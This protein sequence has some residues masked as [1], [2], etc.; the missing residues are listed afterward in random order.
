V[1]VAVVAVRMVQ[2][3]VH[4]VVRVIAMRHGFMPAVG[5]MLV[6]GFVSPAVVIGRAVGRV[7]AVHLEPVIVHVILVGMVHVSVV[8]IVGVPFVHHGRMPAAGSMFV[9]MVRVSIV[10]HLLSSWSGLSRGVLV[11]QEPYDG[12]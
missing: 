12:G 6:A 7:P 8:Q 11:A 2:V 4:Q 9:R 1:I 10:C 3:T 5:S